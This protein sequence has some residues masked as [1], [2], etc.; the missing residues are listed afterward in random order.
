MLYLVP[1]N[2][3]YEIFSPIVIPNHKEREVFERTTQMNTIVRSSV[4]LIAYWVFCEGQ[5]DYSKMDPEKLKYIDYTNELLNGS[6]QLFLKWGYGGPLHN[7]GCICWTSNKSSVPNAP[8]YRRSLTYYNQTIPECGHWEERDTYWAAGATNYTP[9][10]GVESFAGRRKET[11]DYTLLFARP[12]CFVMGILGDTAAKQ[13]NATGS[14][15]V[16]ADNSTCQLWAQRH[17]N[18]ATDRKSCEE[19]FQSNCSSILG[20]GDW[21]RRGHKMCNYTDETQDL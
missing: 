4:L 9:M 6:T 12:T 13:S 2:T 10:V 5:T 8:T 1:S 11:F 15:P 16:E 7:N 21:Y 19:A 17:N 20:E 18:N 3:H 14:P